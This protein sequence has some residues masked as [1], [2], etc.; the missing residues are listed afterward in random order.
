MKERLP[1]MQNQA[2]SYLGRGNSKNPRIERSLLCS[3]HNKGQCG[4]KAQKVKVQ[5]VNRDKTST[6]YKRQHYQCSEKHCTGRFYAW[7]VRIWFEFQKY[8]FNYNR[9]QGTI[10]GIV[11][12]PKKCTE[13]HLHVMWPWPPRSFPRHFQGVLESKIIFIVILR[14]YLSISMCWHLHWQCG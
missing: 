13:I 11:K 9:R 5:E 7:K 12:R 14:L 1:G 10:L 3:T 8:H 4:S 6:L 2:Y